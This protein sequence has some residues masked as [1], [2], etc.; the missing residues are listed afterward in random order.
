[1]TYPELLVK[2]EQLDQSRQ[3]VADQLTRLL[4]PQDGATV[5]F[6]EIDVST[7]N[8]SLSVCFLILNKISRLRTKAI[9]LQGGPM[10]LESLNAE[11]F[12]IKLDAAF[13]SSKI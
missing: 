10:N 2:I 5:T 8:A 3:A 9:L 12:A 11:F 4:K 1:M 7:L 13:F 6:E